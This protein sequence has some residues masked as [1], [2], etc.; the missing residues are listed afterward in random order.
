MARSKQRRLDVRR[1]PA[2]LLPCRYSGK[3]REKSPP[4]VPTAPCVPAAPKHRRKSSGDVCRTRLTGGRCPYHAPFV[5]EQRARPEKTAPRARGRSAGWPSPTTASLSRT[6]DVG[7]PPLGKSL[8]SASVRRTKRLS[9]RGRRQGRCTAQGPDFEL[10]PRIAD[11]D[12]TQEGHGGQPRAVPERRLGGHLDG[13]LP[14]A[15]P[16]GERDTGI[17]AVSGSSATAEERLGRRA[18]L[19]AAAFLPADPAGGVGPVRR[20]R[21]RPGANES[22]RR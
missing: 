6:R 17:Q 20:G 12:P 22:R 4:P 13:T 15:V 2:G 7:A 10:S 5:G 1:R 11:Q 16:I 18:P 14:L 9:A 8:P 19:R 3:T 21:R